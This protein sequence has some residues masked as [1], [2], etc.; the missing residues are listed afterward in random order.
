MNTNLGQMERNLVLFGNG[1]NK[2]EKCFKNTN[3]VII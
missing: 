1:N 3:S 2:I